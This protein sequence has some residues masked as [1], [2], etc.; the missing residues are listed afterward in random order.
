MRKPDITVVVPLYNKKNEIDRC[1]QSILGQSSAAAEIVV[2]DDGST[3]GSAQWVS[4]HY[5]HRVKLVRQAN[6]GVSSARNKGIEVAS[7]DY[8]AFLDADDSWADHFLAEISELI[9]Q[10][11]RAEM[12]ATG[13]QF[14]ISGNRYV[15]PKGQR[16]R[17]PQRALLLD[18]FVRASQGDLPFNASSVCLAKSLVSRIGGFPVGE[19]MGEDQDLWARAA[20][21]SQIAY[22]GKQLSFY[23]LDA[24][25][26]ACDQAA[27]DQECPFSQ[28]L[29][30]VARTLAADQNRAGRRLAAQIMRYT[31]GHLVDL[32]A[33]NVRSGSAQTA[34]DLL[35]DNRSRRY[36]LRWCYWYIRAWLVRQGALI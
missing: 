22:S 14:C 18:Y 6:G 11:P 28:R 29:H 35:A 2:V 24:D 36:P 3:D 12:F 30:N 33:R 17:G 25:A 34:L 27:P 20:L 8:V 10:F 16:R 9:Q 15:D 31:G 21:Y 19:V 13:Y 1:L 4:R 5:A 7:C 26:R 23:H 32:A